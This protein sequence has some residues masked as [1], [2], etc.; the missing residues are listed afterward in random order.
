MKS[1]WSDIHTTFATYP[2]TRDL[3]RL[4]M[5]AKWARELY[6]PY[7]TY[8]GLS[9]TQEEGVLLMW[10]AGACHARDEEPDGSE[11]REKVYGPP[12]RP[13]ARK[14]ERALLKARPHWL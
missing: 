5:G 1:P 9:I 7:Y 4:S 6:L 10:G 13:C 3:L 8:V 2:R 11:Y 12:L 14:A